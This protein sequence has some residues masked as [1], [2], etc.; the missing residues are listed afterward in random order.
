MSII[1]ISLDI[2]GG[3]PA[4]PG[5]VG[6]V[7]EWTGRIGANR[8]SND[9]VIK[10]DSHIGTHIDAP[11]HFIKDGASVERLD[12]NVLCG[13]VTVADL[14]G[15]ESIGRRELDGLALSGDLTRLLFKTD[16]S[17][18]RTDA[19]FVR[20]F[21]ALTEDGGQWL[22]E[23]GVKLVGIDYLS[24]GPFPD[25]AAV[26]RIVLGAGIVALEGLNLAN[27]APGR[28]E[29]ICLPLKVV[30]AEGAPARAVLRTIEGA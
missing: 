11:L 15:T 28:Y 3:M 1:D 19:G 18:L 27:V 29:L 25:G 20:D 6:F 2:Y 8:A 23:R 5:S 14:T 30:G 10:C 17:R 26:H 9:S 21:V 22:V 24:I 12:L 13:T 4:W 7:R 16:N